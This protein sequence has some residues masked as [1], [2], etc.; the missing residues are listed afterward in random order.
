MPVSL[1]KGVTSV[2]ICALNTLSLNSHCI[3][4]FSESSTNTA[5]NRVLV[6]EE[7]SGIIFL[8]KHSYINITG[9]SMCYILF[10]MLNTA[11]HFPNVLSR[12]FFSFGLH[13]LSASNLTSFVIS[14]IL[15]FSIFCFTYCL[16]L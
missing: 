1:V 6:N 11:F 3:V 14:H 9:V 12:I 4:C 5:Q 16:T 2:M 13:C 15:P 7:W 8:Y 10:R